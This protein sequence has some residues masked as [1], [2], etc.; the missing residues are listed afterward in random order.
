MTN[1]TALL[2]VISRI[3][4]KSE[5]AFHQMNTTFLCS[6]IT[7]RLHPITFLLDAKHTVCMFILYI[8]NALSFFMSFLLLPYVFLINKVLSFMCRNCCRWIHSFIWYMRTN[9][10]LWSTEDPSTF[11]DSPEDNQNALKS[12]SA[13]ELT[14]SCSRE[15]MVFAIMNSIRDLPDV[16]FHPFSVSI[17]YIC[18]NWIP[19]N[20][21]IMNFPH[22]F[23][24]WS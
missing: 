6:P 15:S 20:V 8:N 4:P 21:W 11:Y 5:C 9:F 24:S 22:N 18:L 17:S 2:H 1:T 16:I 23:C 3:V 14:N 12:L 19:W 7:F 13:V 10:R